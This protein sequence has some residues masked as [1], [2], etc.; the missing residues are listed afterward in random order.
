MTLS[1]FKRICVSIQFPIS[2]QI[3]TIWK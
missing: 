3:V 2:I 1:Y